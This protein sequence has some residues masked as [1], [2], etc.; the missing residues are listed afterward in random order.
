M[1]KY[2]IPLSFV[3]MA[4]MTACS[5]DENNVIDEN[6]TIQNPTSYTFQ[7]NSQNTVDFSGQSTRL[8]MG[9]ELASGL[10][11]P[12][13]TAGALLAM[14]AHEEGENNFTLASLNASN[15]NLRSKTAASLDYFSTNATNQALIRADFENWI[16]FQ[17]DEVFPN[18]NSA[19]AAGV[20][21]QLEDGSSTRYVN[22][23]GLEYDQMVIKG[24]IGALVVDQTL[25]NYLSPAVLDE[26]D[27]RANNDLAITVEGKSYTAMEHFWDEAYGYV[28]GLNADPANPNADLGADSFLNKYIGRVEGD[29]DFAG[30]ANTIFDAF[31]LGRAA[32]V[33]GDYE[34]RNAQSEI[35]KKKISEIVGIRAVYY[36]Q[37]SKASLIQ[38]VPAYGTAFHDLSEG[39]GF[40]Y[41]L[42]FTKNPISDAPYFSKEEVDVLLID[43]IDDGANGLWDVQISTLDNISVA[44]ADRFEFT[45]EQAAE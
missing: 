28:F 31:K 25:N 30:I 26:G 13:K 24:L 11:S 9:G 32:I 19:A 36:L 41:S 44:I 7:R 20:S 33:A 29:E 42:Q 39:Y 37:Q 45:L 3:V 5:S 6:S 14:F 1:K 27:N 40:I 35:I 16:N 4:L 17:V 21:G 43:L 23:M 8:V 18:W 12:E 38:E 15:K 2:F 34:L 10:I 22:S